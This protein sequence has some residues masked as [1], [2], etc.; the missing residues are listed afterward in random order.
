V[1]RLLDFTQDLTD[2]ELDTLNGW[3]HLLVLRVLADPALTQIAHVA[4]ACAE[5]IMPGIITRN[6]THATPGFANAV[7]TYDDN[8]RQALIASGFPVEGPSPG[9][10]DAALACALPNELEHENAQLRAAYTEYVD[11]LRDYINTAR[12]ISLAKPDR[13]QMFTA[14]PIV[15]ADECLARLAAM[16]AEL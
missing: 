9:A 10:V 2:P 12:M 4:D 15:S 6:W 8:F 7:A 1:R 3:K 14:T 13:D 16:V 11:T 5:S